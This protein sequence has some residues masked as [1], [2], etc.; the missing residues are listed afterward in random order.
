M[1]NL[2]PPVRLIRKPAIEQAS[3]ETVFLGK[4][5]G[6][7]E[8]H[9]NLRWVRAIGGTSMLLGLGGLVFQ[10]S[11]FWW[12]AVFI[13]AGFFVIAIDLLLEPE[14]K[15]WFKGTA[16][17][18][19]LFFVVL[20]SVGFVF[21]SAPVVFSSLATDIEYESG[22]DIHGIKWKKP[23][24]ELNLIVTNPTDGN[25]D[26]VDI[27][28]T[29][30]MPVAAISQLS[31][32]SDVSFEDYFG[33]VLR[34]TVQD[35]STTVKTPLDFIA[36]DAGYRIHCGRIPPQSSL[37]IIMAIVN[38]KEFGPVKKG[39]IP[40]QGDLTPSQVSLEQTMTSKDGT[41]GH[42]W[43]GDVDKTQIYEQR[44]G[45]K[46]ISIKGHYTA[47]NRRRQVVTEVNIQARIN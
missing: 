6:K 36:T 43:F 45:A 44:A 47:K 31:N 7:L 17:A 14:L 18:A 30:D 42:Y 38:V 16:L 34:L 46:K 40:W 10:P 23:Y 41:I 29:P 28:V 27:V 39:P 21:V 24:T 11:L 22:A 1:V 25:Y 19:I 32:L 4:D 15:K 33:V 12:A 9:P 2:P 26:D 8:V 37:R 35:L 20:F 3:K 13:Y 5:S